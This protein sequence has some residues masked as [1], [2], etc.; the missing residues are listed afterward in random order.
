L[1]G[2][3]GGS[4][5]FGDAVPQPES[6]REASHHRGVRAFVGGRQGRERAAVTAADAPRLNAAPQVFL[7]AAR[8]GLLGPPTA[9]S[10][11]VEEFSSRRTLPLGKHNRNL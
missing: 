5:R 11:V 6:R 10:L 4:L 8:L 3:C 7:A 2:F 1:N 9:P